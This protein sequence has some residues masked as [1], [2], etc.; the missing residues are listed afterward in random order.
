MQHPRLSPGARDSLGA[1]LGS[2]VSEHSA[3]LNALQS[4]FPIGELVEVMLG[5]LRT[6]TAAEQRELRSIWWRQRRLGFTFP[7]QRGIIV[8]AGGKP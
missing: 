3:A 8:I 4:L 6:P 7:A 5:T 2:E 1:S